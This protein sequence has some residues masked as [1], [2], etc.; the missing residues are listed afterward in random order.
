[1][2]G[3]CRRPLKRSWLSSLSTREKKLAGDV[4]RIA[5]RSSA[6]G[7]Q[8][9]SYWDLMRRGNAEIGC[10]ST[11]SW[12]LVGSVAPVPTSRTNPRC[13]NSLRSRWRVRRF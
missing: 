4:R 11:S 8:E 9:R 12:H 1:M 5:P 7:R 6:D 13:I 10:H 3:G 2:V